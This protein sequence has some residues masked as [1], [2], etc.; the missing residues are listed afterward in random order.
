MEKLPETICVALNL[1]LEKIA[2]NHAEDL[3]FQINSHREYLDQF[4]DWTKFNNTLQDALE[5]VNRSQLEA[6]N[7][8]SFTW[9][10][11]Y[12]GRAVGTISFNSLIDWQN[13][14]VM[15]GYWLS[16]DVQKKGIITHSIEQLIERTKSYFNNYILKCAEHNIRSNLVAQRCGFKFIKKIE[17]GEQ[18]CGK[19]YT[20]NMYQKQI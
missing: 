11:C 13:K 14:T 8:E 19:W 3:L 20:Q 4:V 15:I 7:G 6:K 18:I 9:A 2:E 5:F 1:K 12:Q 17:N 10:I 16:P